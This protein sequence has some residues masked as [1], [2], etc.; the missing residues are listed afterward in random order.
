MLNTFFLIQNQCNNTNKQV[1]MEKM[2]EI[3][4]K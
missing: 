4:N 2:F 3:V 1:F